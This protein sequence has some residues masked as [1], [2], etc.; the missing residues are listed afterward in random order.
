MAPVAIRSLITFVAAVATFYFVLWVPGSLL[1]L[2]GPFEILAPLLAL[3]CAASVGKFAWRHSASL[4][5]GM[6][7][8]AG[9][10]ALIVGGVGFVGGFFGPMI[11]APEA[12][13][14]P[15][16]GLFITGPGGAVIGAIGG[17]LLRSARG[18]AH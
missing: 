2:L 8:Y 12:N 1:S 5:G 16:L 6:T 18:G 15:L 17:A 4:E 9:M 14:G 10:G 13:Q 3:A 11:F 7:V